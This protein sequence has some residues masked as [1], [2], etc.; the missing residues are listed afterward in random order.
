MKA[1]EQSGKSGLASV[2]KV[3]SGMRLN[4]D[5]YYKSKER[6]EARKSTE[7]KVIGL[8]R[9]AR[10]IQSRAGTKSRAILLWWLIAILP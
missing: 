2:Q 7:A 8:V 1:V 6:L 10:K 3:Y 5:A 9:E 4:R